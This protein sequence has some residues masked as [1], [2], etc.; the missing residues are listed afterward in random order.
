M[1]EALAKPERAGRGG[2]TDMAEKRNGRGKR[3][4]LACKNRRRFLIVCGVIAAGII[5]GGAGVIAASLPRST[6][7][8]ELTVVIDPGHGGGDGGALGWKTKVREDE[9]NLQVALLLGERLQQAGMTVVYTR[10]DDKGLVRDGVS[11]DK[12]A[13]MRMRAEIMEKAKPDL[14]V[15]I[16]MNSH[17]DAGPS[18]PQVFSQTGSV[19]GK[20]LA[21]AIQRQFPVGIPEARVRHAANG[22]YFVLRAAEAPSVMVECGFLSNAQ[23]ETRLQDPDYQRRLSWCVYAGVISYFGNAPEP[24]E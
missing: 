3:K 6:P 5:V 15:S 9:L 14:V 21:E 2:T 20:Q 10:I 11:W 4:R 19:K 13:D 18:G 24:M 16:H 7:V 12:N 17:T 23:D 1:I 22:N 8:S